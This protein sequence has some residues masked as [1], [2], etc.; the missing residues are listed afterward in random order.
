MS[1]KVLEENG[2]ASD[3]EQDKHLP[4]SLVCA[5]MDYTAGNLA[6]LAGL[7]TSACGC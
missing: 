1:E 7:R 6:E 4:F 2:L 5:A 3:A